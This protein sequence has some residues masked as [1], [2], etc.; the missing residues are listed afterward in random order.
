MTGG[1]VLRIE[2][3]SVSFNA[4]RSAHV[5]VDEAS[6]VV[7]RQ[8]IVGVIGE[9]GSGKTQLLL[10]AMGLL[11]PNA[12]ATGS[13]KFMGTELLGLPEKSLDRFRGAVMSMVFQDPMTS[14]NPVMSIAAQLIEVLVAH[15]GLR[16]REALA[17]AISMLDR[18]GLI[19]ASRRIHDYPHE[20]SGGMR[21]RVMLAMAMLCEPCVLLADEPTTALDMTVQAEMLELLRSACS[22]IGTAILLVTH[23]LGVVA[24][25]C[26]RV[27]VLYSGRVVES[28]PIDRVLVRPRHP[29]TQKLIEA[30]PRLD[31]PLVPLA[32]I[33]GQPPRLRGPLSGCPFE[34]RCPERIGACSIETPNIQFS[35]DATLACHV[36][37]L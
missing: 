25:L 14:L 32:A 12:R 31:R 17:R 22:S 28:G 3:L 11:S 27:V 36:E 29:Y 34:P 33:V 2:R 1:P 5:A 4:G 21:Q 13:I 16:R 7:G 24:S 26:Q 30:T 20:F 8:E 9:S 15:R 6:L 37:T 19:D 35:Q 18:V 10:A 23:D